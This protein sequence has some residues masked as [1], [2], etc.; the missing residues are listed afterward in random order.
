MQSV[1]PYCPICR[2]AIKPSERYEHTK[3]IYHHQCFRDR[4]NRTRI[5]RLKASGRYNPVAQKKRAAFLR[6]GLICETFVSNPNLSTNQLA[7]MFGLSPMMITIIIKK[8]LGDGNMFT[9]FIDAD[10]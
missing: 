4:E 5:A 10:L 6:N 3:K 9:M 1:K 7:D 8:Y 2:S